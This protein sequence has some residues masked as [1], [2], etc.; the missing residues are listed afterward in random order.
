MERGD[1]VAKLLGPNSPW[2]F[3]R[4]DANGETLVLKLQH[5]L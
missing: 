3:E 1:I 4:F 5:R 2:Y